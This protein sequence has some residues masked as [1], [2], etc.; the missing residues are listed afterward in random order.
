MRGVNILQTNRA[1]TGTA[2]GSF[3]SRYHERLKERH[4]GA[5]LS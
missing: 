2:N 3:M 5:R 4:A 1:G